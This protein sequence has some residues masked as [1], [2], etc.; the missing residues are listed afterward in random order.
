MSRERLLQ[1]AT[2]YLAFGSAVSIL[3]SI[4]VSQI[5]L[6]LALASLLC[7][8][9][10]LEFP[11]VRLPIATFFVLTVA[12]VLASGDPQR[13]M[14]QIRKFFVFAIV[15]V[16]FSTFRTVRQ[17]RGLIFSWTVVAAGSGLLGT[18][19]F[20]HRRREALL[21]HADKYAF[22]VD[23]RITGFA[24]HW[25][26]FG[27]E[28]MIVLLML[29]S[30]LLLS[31]LPRWRFFLWPA[32]ILIWTSVAL[33]MTRCIFLL[34]LPLGILYLAWRRRKLYMVAFVLGAAVGIVL[35]PRAVRERI[36][37]VVKPHY[38]IDSNAQRAI[39]RIVGWQMVKAHP[40][41]GLGPE[42]IARQFSGYV[43]ASVLRPLPRGWYGH[44]HNLYLQYA[45][46]RGLPA[47]LSFFWLI[48]VMI[49][50]FLQVVRDPTLTKEGRAVINGA[51]GV[52][53]AVLA[54]G[55]FEYNLG[56]SEVLTMFLSVIA[57][58][59][60]VVRQLKEG[61][62]SQVHRINATE[63]RKCGSSLTAV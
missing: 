60:V 34:G 51:L 17:V 50:D 42:Q 24:S 41:L 19:Q 4:A 25:M 1:R 5:L 2:F 40:W 28:E 54:E 36:V 57:C 47:L 63:D 56:D 11:P 39:C 62:A 12:A 15:L 59:Y 46:E 3:L 20:L 43:P 31:D 45:A 37:S 27:G 30:V 6:A 33:G 32:A 9:R 61:S 10:K 22:I 48:G 49:F 52:I 53:I 13:A 35:A 26:T 29:I 14:P 18:A 55:L 8:G 21:Q 7:S 58:G 44:L 16:V 38:G 23:G